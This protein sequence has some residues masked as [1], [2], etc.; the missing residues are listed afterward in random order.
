MLVACNTKSEIS[1]AKRMLETSKS[2]FLQGSDMAAS[3]GAHQCKPTILEKIGTK[4]IPADMLTK[5]FLGVE[6][7]HCLN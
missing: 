7:K 2:K 3:L 5:A 6:V 1:R 4:D